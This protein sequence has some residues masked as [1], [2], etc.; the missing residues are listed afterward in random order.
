MSVS[1]TTKKAYEGAIARIVKFA[2]S[3]NIYDSNLMVTAVEAQPVGVHSKKLYYATLAHFT[4]DRPETNTIYKDK[5]LTIAKAL[6]TKALEQKKNDK[7]EERWMDWPDIQS[8]GLTIM[9]DT[10]LSLE[11]RILA[12][13]YTQIPPAR[14]DYTD[15][16]IYTGSPPLDSSGNY[17]LVTLNGTMHME[18]FIQD[19]KTTK[20]HGTLRRMLPRP[21]VSLV[22]TWMNHHPPG[23]VLFA[24]VKP[25][26]L[27]DRIST[28]FERATGKHI[29]SSLIR[30]SYITH[31]RKGDLPIKARNELSMTMGHDLFTNELYRRL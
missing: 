7:E 14:L 9:R 11:T 22:H 21:L 10:S 2:N 8:A 4:R 31:V 20:S 18:V 30:K 16:S 28:M 15:L 5:M 25:S 23:T 27:C 1:E 6:T 19:H 26:T 3:N 17:I 12:G 24:N 29:T 13:L